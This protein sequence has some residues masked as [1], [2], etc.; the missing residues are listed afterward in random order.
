MTT[1]GVL[2]DTH[3]P[4]RVSTL[5]ERVGRIFKQAG[6]SAILHAGDVIEPT[7]LI[8]LGKIAPVHAVR[9]NRDIFYLNNL[10]LRLVLDVE[11]VTI[12][13]AHG[14]HSFPAYIVD[15]LRVAFNSWS[16]DI[17]IQRLQQAFPQADV[18]VFGHLHLPFNTTLDGKLLFNPG[19]TGQPMQRGAPP[20][21]GL[22]HIGESKAVRGEII[23]LDEA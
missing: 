6:V 12:G 11:G 19:S 18:I 2:A 16:A 8:E 20:T 15:R 3:I 5:D 9:G 21:V 13:M 10:P 4:D 1:L 22:L 23:R 14:H 17:Y 7:I